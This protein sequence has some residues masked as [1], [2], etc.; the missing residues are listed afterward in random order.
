MEN[1]PES[2]A[3]VKSL[4]KFINNSA[5][6]QT[7]LTQIAQNLGQFFRIDACLIVSGITSV[8]M[9][10]TGF[11]HKEGIACAEIEA[12]FSHD[13]FNHILTVSEPFSLAEWPRQANSSNSGCVEQ[14]LSFESSLALKTEFQGTANGL[15]W[16]GDNKTHVW[17]ELEKNY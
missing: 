13:L 12:L 2:D 15:I 6:A 17:T 4:I 5:D 7:L 11:W 14:L 3:L 1:A 16:L 9:A 10:H 8:E